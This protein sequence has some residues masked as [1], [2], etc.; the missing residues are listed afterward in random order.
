VA[1]AEE[2]A[3]RLQALLSQVADGDG[4]AAVEVQ[5]VHRDL[6]RE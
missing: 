5:V 2:I 1:I 3:R 4:D 6:G